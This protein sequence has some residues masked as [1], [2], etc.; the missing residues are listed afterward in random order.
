MEHAGTGDVSIFSGEKR[1]C[2]EKRGAGGDEGGEA[3][4]KRAKLQDREMD[5]DDG[6]VR[7]NFIP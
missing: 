5:D 7:G 3:V 4:E 6:C 2:V 1:G